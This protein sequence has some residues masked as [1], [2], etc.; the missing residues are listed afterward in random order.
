MKKL[1]SALVCST[2]LLASGVMMTSCDF[3]GPRNEIKIGGRTMGTIYSITVIGEYPGGPEQLKHEADEVLDAINLQISSF[4]KKSELSKF[5]EFHSTEPFKVS[6]DLADVVIA[7]IRAGQ[8]LN[9]AV[10]ITVAPLVNIW[11]FGHEKN[12]TVVPKDE[13]INIAKGKIGLDKIHVTVSS[14]YAELKKDIPNLEID[15][16]TVGEGF[17]ADKLAELMD[18]RGIQNYMVSVAGAIRT[19]GHNARG[20]DWVVAIE[21]P[22]TGQA[23]GQ[24]LEIPVCTGGQALSTSGSYR[25]YKVDEKTGQRLSHIIDPNTGKPVTHH[26]VSVTVVGPTALWT[27]AVDTGFMVMGSEEALKYANDRNLAI[28]TIVKEGDTFQSHYSRAMQHYLECD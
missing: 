2:M 13:D 23:L 25:N 22:T 27:D 28:Y 21:H 16:S 6:Q 20:T 5:N 10:D 11:G 4:D 17:G 9:G 14:K 19:R 26:T 7:S 24:K 15:L 18:H 8:D 1:L 12:E 3:G